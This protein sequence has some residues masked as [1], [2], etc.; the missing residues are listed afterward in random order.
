MARLLRTRPVGPFSATGIDPALDSLTAIFAE[1]KAAQ[2]DVYPLLGS[3]G[4]VCVRFVRGSKTAL[5]NHSWG[6]AIDLTLGSRLDPYGD[7]RVQQGLADIAPIFNRHGWYW[8]AA[9][10]KEDGMHFEASDQLV[11]HWATHGWR[12]T[13]WPGSSAA[14]AAVEW[15]AVRIGD[16]G[17]S[18][19][20]VQKA[21]LLREDGVFGPATHAAVLA[22]Q[23]ANGLTADGIVGEKTARKLGIDVGG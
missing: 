19:R 1:V 10:G 22:F 15:A 6:T 12:Y 11:R 5:S 18:V 9:F 14:S 7:G 17:R 21:L 13:P 2:P 16:R 20:L 8:G 23:A 3:A 4:M